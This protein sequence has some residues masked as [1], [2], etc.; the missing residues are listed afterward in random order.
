M[1]YT[2]NELE[3]YKLS[4][5]RNPMFPFYVNKRENIGQLI[6]PHWHNEFEFFYLEKG[7]AQCQLNSSSFILNSGEALA[8][9]KEI[10]HSATA[11]NNSSCSLYSIIFNLNLIKNRFKDDCEIKY[12]DPLYNN[13]FQIKPCII[14]NDHPVIKI[15][16]EIITIM[17]NK[18]TAYKLKI[19]S[20]LLNIFYI[21]IKTGE[22]TEDNE[23]DNNRIKKILA[24][25]HDNYNK[26]ISLK[27]MADILEL[28]K[29]YFLRYFKKQTGKTPIEYLNYYRIN[30]AKEIFQQTDK[31]VMQ[32]ALDVGFNNLSYFIKVFKKH[33][34]CT[35]L[36]YKNQSKNN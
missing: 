9:N 20:L 6:T 31:Q 11:L 18:N 17:E 1:E 8:I 24:Y 12:M 35:P 19:K 16:K 26:E 30:K 34:N 13:K 29:C 3:K 27:E 15:L 36:E 22:M 33:M 28:N 32:V 21:L 4:W 25:I 10:I 7:Q 5:D 2:R 14:N 23:L